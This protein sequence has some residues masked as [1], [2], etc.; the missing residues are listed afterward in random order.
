M[1]AK[2]LYRLLGC[3]G[4]ARIDFFLTDDGEVLLNEIN[5]MP[6]FTAHSRFPM[7]MKEIGISYEEIIE[8]LLILAVENHEKK[9]STIGE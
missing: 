8:K 4:L 7:M 1:K 9:L 6:G 5:T 2:Q 3:T